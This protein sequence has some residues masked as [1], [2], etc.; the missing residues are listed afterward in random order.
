MFDEN[1][2]NAKKILSHIEKVAGERILKYPKDIQEEALQEAVLACLLGE[3]VLEHLK[4]WRRAERA[5]L[6]K[7]L[8]FTRARPTKRDKEEIKRIEKKYR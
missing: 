6:K 3:D 8:T 4:L 5:Y 2:K 1:D 7:I